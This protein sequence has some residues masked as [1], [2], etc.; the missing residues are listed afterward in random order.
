MARDSAQSTVSSGLAVPCD[1]AAAAAIYVTLSL[2][3]RRN[4]PRELSL[5][6]N[7]PLPPWK[8]SRAPLGQFATAERRT[9][10]TPNHRRHLYACSGTAN[11]TVSTPLLRLANSTLYGIAA[12][13]ISGEG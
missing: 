9:H 8:I 6:L 12:C 11:T 10:S 4:G 13:L 3:R 1:T 2:S 5:F 7:P